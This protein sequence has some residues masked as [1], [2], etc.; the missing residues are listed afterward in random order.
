MT[1]ISRK[2]KT[3]L[4]KIT[5]F[6]KLFFDPKTS[7]REAMGY[8]YAMVKYAVGQL[9]AYSGVGA[10]ISFS[11]DTRYSL[12]LTK[13]PVAMVLF[14]DPS[15]MRDEEKIAEMF[16]RAGDV[17]LDVGANIGNFSLFASKIVGKHGKVFAFEAHPATYHYAKRN[18]ALNAMKNIICEQKAV[19]E[20]RGSISFSDDSYDDVNHVQKEGGVSVEMITLDE[21]L[22]LQGEK[23]VAF[24]KI[25]IEGYELFA[26][27]GAATL[28]QKTK[29]VLFEAY[30]KSASSYGYHVEDVY[31]FFLQNGFDIIDP[32]TQTPV[33]RSSLTK[34]SIQNLL[35]INR[36]LVSYDQ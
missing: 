4:L 7:K 11:V 1:K 15:I 8:L 27:E 14:G 33:E 13:S 18:I 29:Y 30:E 6:F 3:L 36:K 22:P 2:A 12:Y 32:F 16:L 26:L 19:G 31:N 34:D 23:I 17:C 35:A 5:T 25:D 10:H 21:Y 9:L 20:K 24:M 28:L